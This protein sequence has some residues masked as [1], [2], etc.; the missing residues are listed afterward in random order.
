MVA[1]IGWNVWEGTNNRICKSFLDIIM[2]V[3]Q[4]FILIS[5]FDRV[6]FIG[7]ML[8]LIL[9]VQGLLKLVAIGLYSLW[10]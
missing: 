7:S 4:L 6:T 9:G 3:Y 2:N 5:T 8:P 1:V 10:R